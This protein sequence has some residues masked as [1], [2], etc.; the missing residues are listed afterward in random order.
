MNRRALDIRLHSADPQKKKRLSNPASYLHGDPGDWNK[1]SIILVLTDA[2]EFPAHTKK[3][4][5]QSREIPKF[6]ASLS[7]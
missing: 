5:Q 2:L 6:R 4:N 3:A 7:S 1:G